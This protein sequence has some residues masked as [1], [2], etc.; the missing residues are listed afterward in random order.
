MSDNESNERKTVT[1]T[2]S[3][4]FVYDELDLAGVMEFDDHEQF[5]EFCREDVQ[6]MLDRGDI[7]V[8]GFTLKVE[9][10]A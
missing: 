7:P 3:A 9:E 10:D 1:V 6:S 8:G 4:S 5:V 2:A